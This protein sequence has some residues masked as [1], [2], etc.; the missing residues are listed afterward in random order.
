MASAVTFRLFRSGQWE[1]ENN[2]SE[3]SYPLGLLATNFA[4]GLEMA[5]ATRPVA[6]SQ[7]SGRIYQAGI[8]P[9]TEDTTVGLI[10]DALLSLDHVPWNA[11]QSVPYPGESRQFCDLELSL[12]G[13]RSYIEV[14]ML[15]M[16]G[17]NGKPND[18]MVN[19]ILS[20]YSRH[21][22]ALTDIDKLRNSQFDGDRA[23]LIYGYDYP[24][25]PVETLLTAFEKLA[26]G[27]ISTP[28]S[29]ATFSGL[30]HPVH[31]EGVVAVWNVNP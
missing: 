29:Q 20:P 28:R 8:G 17:D 15:R 12:D 31:Q 27:S 25:Y 11:V 6:K 24:D 7:R 21:R 1:H 16:M 26:D 14:K 4:R 3:C 30:V 18:N 2:M 23:I 22:S 5:D 13:Q 19:H 9:H 10:L